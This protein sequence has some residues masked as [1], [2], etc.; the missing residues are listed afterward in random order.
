MFSESQ[1]ERLIYGTVLI[2]SIMYNKTMQVIKRRTFFTYNYE[3][4]HD[5]TVASC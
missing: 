5:K 2:E 3:P 1:C 4:T